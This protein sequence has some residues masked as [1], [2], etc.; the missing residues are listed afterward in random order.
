[1]DPKDKIIREQEEQIN[2]LAS[3]LQKKKVDW[4]EI[5]DADIESQYVALVRQ[6]LFDATDKLKALQ[7]KSLEIGKQ[8]YD[9]KQFINAYET[10]LAAEIALETDSD[11]KKVFTNETLRENA[12]M[13][14]LTSS[15]DYQTVKDRLRVVEYEQLRI[16]K[17]IELLD[18]DCKNKRCILD[19]M[20]K[21]HREKQ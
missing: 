2:I 6:D 3:K 12:L 13:K 10:K 21:D 16:T 4:I 17:D 9:D 7:E 19:S 14:R 15:R 20:P 18:F 11:G 5:T 1:M 8:I